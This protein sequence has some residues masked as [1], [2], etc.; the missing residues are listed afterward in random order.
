MTDKKMKMKMKK[1]K[2][3]LIGIIIFIAI[4]IGFDFLRIAYFPTEGEKFKK[5]V[6]KFEKEL[7]DIYKKDI[8]GGETPEITYNL[9]INAL[10]EGD[11][12]IASK[13]FFLSDWDKKQAQFKEKQDKGELNEYINNLPKWEELEAIDRKD[14]VREYKY[15][16]FLKEGIEY[17]Q[18]GKGGVIKTEFPAGEYASSII[19]R[20]NDLN[21]IWKIYQGI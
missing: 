20:F 2:K 6:E 18:N 12:E 4:I 14:G 8:Y 1:W 17:L 13:Y 21:K 10:K 7:T 19:F 3:I 16:R 11:I 15:K 9:F 5:D